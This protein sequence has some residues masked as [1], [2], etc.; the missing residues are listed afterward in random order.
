MFLMDK[1]VDFSRRSFLAAASA[2]IPAMAANDHLNVAWIGTGT[3][4]YYL[5]QRYFAGGN[6]TRADVVAVCDAYKGNLAKA[7]DLV[8]TEYG[9][10]PKTYED[11]HELLK[12][13]SIDAVVIASPEH[14]HYP[15]FMAAIKAGK[16]IYVE[17]P[18]AHTIE[19][20]AEMVKAAEKAGKVVQVGTQNRSNSLYIKAKEM[21]AEGMIGDIHYVRAFWYRNSRDDNPA[22]RYKIPADADESNTDWKRF[23]EG[24][25]KRP[26]DLH[27]FYQ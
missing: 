16:N 17:K 12:D 24:A 21:V 8:S 7:K 14:L 15:M 1:K 9:K 18:L 4:G 23:L 19:E 27:R 3:R 22:W 2:A 11:Y 26:F 5:M 20:G 25:P 13:P 10:A 6:K